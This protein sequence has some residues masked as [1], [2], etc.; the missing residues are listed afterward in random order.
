MNSFPNRLSVR[1]DCMLLLQAKKAMD[2]LDIKYEV[3]ELDKREDGQDIQVVAPSL[4]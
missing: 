1:A 3:M 2:Q 4:S